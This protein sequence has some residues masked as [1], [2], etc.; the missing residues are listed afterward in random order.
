MEKG[1][2]PVIA[3][4]LLIAIAIMGSVTVWY[5]SSIYTSKPA[6]SDTTFKSYTVT[7]V[8]RDGT[9]IRCNAIDVKNT[10]KYALTS[11][12]LNVRDTATGMQ[13][14]YN[15]TNPFFNAYINISNLSVGDTKLFY[16]EGTGVPGWT[17]INTSNTPLAN[18]T[19]YNVRDV[20]IG[21]ANNDGQNEIVV[22]GG[23][24]GYWNGTKMFKNVSGN[25]TETNVSGNTCATVDVRAVAIGDVNND[26]QNEIVSGGGYSNTPV[27]MY[28][29][30]S[31]GWTV[32]TIGTAAW[33]VTQIVVGDAD[34]DGKNEIVTT[35]YQWASPLVTMFKNTSGNWT[36]TTI[37]N[38]YGSGVNANSVA[39]NDVDND[40]TKEVVVGLSETTNELRMYKNISGGWQ[41]TNISDPGTI[42]RLVAGDADNDGKNEIV[43]GLT[44]LP[45]ATRM[46]KNTSGTW[47]E[48]NLTNY[49]S[50]GASVEIGDANNDGKNETLIA[51]SVVPQFR[52]FQNVSGSWGESAILENGFL[53]STVSGSIAVGDVNNDGKKEVFVVLYDSAMNMYGAVLVAGGEGWTTVPFGSYILRPSSAGFVDQRLTCT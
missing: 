31:G 36:N 48:R 25:W 43:V 20:V 28:K 18:F 45:V 37:K 32:T 14:G 27:K 49:D 23:T 33:T 24:A 2:S 17:V 9:D 5:W 47:I 34:N 15:G 51:T 19:L 26:G 40:G 21:D 4:V 44:G 29:N 41:E 42:G 53:T 30:E 35:G 39:I 8:Y 16:I 3:T 50:N 6:L 13:V 46:Y 52:L 11:A 10:G 22:G 12:V 1:V 38:N 7:A